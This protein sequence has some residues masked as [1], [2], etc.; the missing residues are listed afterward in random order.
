MTL[1]LLLF[2]IGIM[3]L[4]ADIFVSSFVMA[5]VGGVAMV[6][7]CVIAY[8]DFGILAAGLAAV[9]AIVLF[10]AAI[11]IELVLLPK[12]RVGR[13]LVV[14][15]TLRVEQ[16][17]PGRPGHVGRGK[18]GDSRHDPGPERLRARRGAPVR[19]LLPDRPRR[20]GHGPQGHRHG[21]FPPY[22]L[23]TYK[24]PCLIFPSSSLIPLGSSSAWLSSE[25]SFPTL[26]PGSRPA[27]TAH[28]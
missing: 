2:I 15:S 9:T 8:R 20:P 12:T 23:Q 19:G 5:A 28:P 18:A 10:G 1:I 11:Y 4:A 22:R 7:G 24:I 3:L 13:G 14:E 6:A 21:Q 26:A 27:S 17:A 16:P 25:S